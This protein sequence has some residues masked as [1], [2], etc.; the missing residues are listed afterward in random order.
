MDG[1]DEVGGREVA[2]VAARMV[3]L[4]VEEGLALAKVAK[5]ARVAVVRGEAPLEPV[6]AEKDREE[7]AM[8]A[9]AKAAEALVAGC[10]GKGWAVVEPS[11]AAE[12]MAALPGPAPRVE[13]ERVAVVVVAIREPPVDIGTPP[14]RQSSDIERSRAAAPS[15]TCPRYHC[16]RSQ[17]DQTTPALSPDLRTLMRMAPSHRRSAHRSTTPRME[18]AIL[19]KRR[20]DCTQPRDRRAAT[21]PAGARTPTRSLL[22]PSRRARPRRHRW[23]WWLGK[24]RGRQS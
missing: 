9:A 1:S 4:V 10:W 17:M 24:R 21:R 12:S 13:V 7:G 23:R 18:T 6:V 8:A 16:N 5:V 22:A 2:H 3:A 15:R 11:D 14:A 20:R 19:H